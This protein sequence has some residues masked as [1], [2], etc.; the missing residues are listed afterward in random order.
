MG[1]K[2]TKLFLIGIFFAFGFLFFSNSAS[3]ATCEYAC[4]GG[5]QPVANYEC[6]TGCN[7]DQVCCEIK[8]A[9]K[10]SNGSA[11][12]SNSQCQSGFC[13]YYDDF[14]GVCE[15][16]AN[17]DPRNTGTPTYPSDP[18]NPVNTSNPTDPAV[19]GGGWSLGSVSK[20]GLPQGSVFGIISNILVWLLGI[21]GILGVIGFV[22]SGI[23]YLLSTGDET[24]IERAKK[25]MQWSIVG[26]IVALLGVVIIQAIDLMLREFSFF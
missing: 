22:I 24:M 19:A 20:F 5:Q 1:T 4:S 17:Q 25:A 2:Q 23:I 3:A 18:A 12:T 21:L 11:C 8:T 13:N 14:N 7:S 10:A 9:T 6:S 15:A 26:I 16:A